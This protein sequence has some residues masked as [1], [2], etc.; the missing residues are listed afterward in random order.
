MRLL[1]KKSVTSYIKKNIDKIPI[2][3]RTT[4]TYGINLYSPKLRKLETNGNKILF[5]LYLRLSRVP[6]VPSCC[7]SGSKAKERNC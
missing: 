2:E 4:N 7:I 6:S 1:V 3:L 5:A